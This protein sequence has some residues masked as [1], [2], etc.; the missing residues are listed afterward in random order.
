MLRHAYVVAAVA[1]LGLLLNS[2]CSGDS[3]AFSQSDPNSDSFTSPALDAAGS[4][5]AELP[6]DFA[7]PWEQLDTAGHVL[8]A[9][10]TASC[11]NAQS[12]F[13]SGV[14]REQSSLAGLTENGEAVRLSSGDVGSGEVSWA[15]WRLTMGGVQPGAVSA[16]V[17]VL[18]MN[19]GDQS[20]YYLGLS[21]Y[22]GD[23]WR[24][25]GPF[26]ESHVRLSTAAAIAGGSDFLSPQGNLF[27]CAVASAG[28]TFDVVGVAANP[29]GVGDT[30]APPV[31]TGL[32][33]T[34]IAGGLEL[35]WEDVIAGDVAGYQV[36]WRSGWFL[37]Q[38]ATGI[39]CLDSLEGQSHYLL[40]LDTTIEMYVRISA[41]DLSGNESDLSELVV[42]VPLP[43][44]APDLQLTTDAPSGMLNDTISLTAAGADSYDW[45]LDGD[46]IYEVT[47]DHGGTQAADTSATGMIRPAVRGSI[48]GGT[49]IA[50]GSVSLLIAGNA[51]PVANGYAEPSAGPAPLTVD[52]TG[53]GTDPDGEIVLYSWDFDGNGSYD[54]SDPENSNPPDQV[55]N[56]PFLRN[57]KF[58]VDDNQGAYDVD[59]VAI[60]ILDPEPGPNDSPVA[61]VSADK[62]SSYWPF[63]ITFDASASSDA[64]GNI[65][66][67]AWDFDAD[68]NFEE[69]GAQA[70][71]INIFPMRGVYSVLLQVTDDRGASD[72]DTL[73]VTLPSEWWMCGMGP[74]HNR[75]SPYVGSQTNNLKWAFPTLGSI[76]SSPTIGAD[77]TIYVGSSDGVI[78]AINPSGSK[79][80][81]INI[82]SW[83]VTAP[84]VGVD[85][86]IYVGVN[87]HKL[88][89]LNPDATE[90]WSFTAGS[91]IRSSPAIGYDG[92]VYVGSDDNTLYAINP[93]GTEKWSFTTGGYIGSSPAIGPDGTIYVGSDDRNLYA[94]YPWGAQ[95]WAFYTGDHIYSSPAVGADGTVYVGGVDTRLYAVNPTGSEKWHYNTGSNIYSSPAIGANGT[96]YVGCDDMNLYAI[97]PDGNEKWVFPT[98]GTIFSSPAIGADGMVYVGSGDGKINAINS[99]GIE[100]WTYSTGGAVFSSPAISNAGMVIVGSHDFSLYAIGPP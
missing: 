79:K 82:G 67:Y 63:K 85:G 35:T 38:Q 16:D 59:T 27:V 14:E 13:R 89:A 1:L 60:L 68:G 88:Y 56:I 55:Y 26:S 49:A 8:P 30:E 47:G 58:R 32:S 37:D 5:P 64:D 90:K 52:F 33:V 66:L 86:T 76:S 44:I 19:N 46:G 28:A 48:G 51:R 77:G 7:Q 50:Q 17:N 11:I 40:K 43:G 95:K 75:Q 61:Q 98:G 4:W 100:E 29:V 53:S 70:T 74:M 84:A 3:V 12:E 96:V 71:A 39:Q 41:I 23:C 15:Y 57:V 78:Y 72:T 65:S 87:N 31:P 80:W 81:S 69:Q 45:D 42:A 9:G 93:D 97:S 22:G 20:T 21:D 25:C 83:I 18:P 6:A 54:W 91:E 99:S 10:R 34:P 92:T 62:T 94:I 24:W 2:G 36:Y 73:F